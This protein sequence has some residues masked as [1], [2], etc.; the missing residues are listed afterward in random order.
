MKNALSSVSREKQTKNYNDMEFGIKSK[1]NS[2][3][4]GFNL[5]DSNINGRNL[6][7]EFN[8]NRKLDFYSNTYKPSFN[9]YSKEKMLDSQREKSIEDK[10][11]FNYVSRTIANSDI[12]SKYKKNNGNNT[13]NRSNEFNSSLG[14]KRVN[15]HYT[16]NFTVTN[17]NKV[18]YQNKSNSKSNS[19]IKSIQEVDNIQSKIDNINHSMNYTGKER[20]NHE[21]SEKINHFRNASKA[22]K[23][24]RISNISFVSK[25]SDLSRLNFDNFNQNQRKVRFN[26][27]YDYNRIETQLRSNTECKNSFKYEN[28]VVY[29]KNKIKKL[30]KA[31]KQL[32]DK[33]QIYTSKDKTTL[34]YEKKCVKIIEKI[35][36]LLNLKTI[37][38]TY[39]SIVNVL[40]GKIN[41]KNKTFLKQ[42]EMKKLNKYKEFY[43]RSKEVYDDLHT[44]SKKFV[45]NRLNELDLK[46]NLKNLEKDNT[47]ENLSSKNRDNWKIDDSIEK[48]TDFSKSKI[49]KNNHTKLHS[50]IK[51]MNSFNYNYKNDFFIHE[52]KSVWRWIKHM[53]N[54]CY[55]DEFEEI[56]AINQ[57]NVNQFKSKHKSYKNNYLK[58]INYGFKALTD[59]KSI[60]KSRNVRSKSESKVI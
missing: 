57:Q 50:E 9:I 3:L 26:L 4:K 20:V 6:E 41:L 48:K 34:P 30:E 44:K 25:Q 51:K 54:I 24:S 59:Q 2:N 13:S 47:Y 15:Y 43:D 27:N 32:N 28:D 49:K 46:L 17:I 11:H 19:K 58:P 22:S 7:S 23:V 8:S 14:E 5:F 38:D 21:S 10:L 52:I 53:I 39:N 42:D 33:L 56:N 37:N 1:N 55:N 31:N 18:D 29:L 45:N 36:S 35:Q 60:K 40:D 12:Y 16:P